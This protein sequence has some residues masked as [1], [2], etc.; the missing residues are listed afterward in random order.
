M[1]K[2]MEFREIPGNF[3][4]LYNTEFSGIPRNLSQFR[5]E[6]GIDGS[7]KNRRNSVSAEFRGHPI[8]RVSVPSSEIGPKGDNTRLRVRGRGEPIRTTGEKACH[9]V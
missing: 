6:Y 9:S 5:T 3:T 2:V 4:E 7:K 8:T 1:K